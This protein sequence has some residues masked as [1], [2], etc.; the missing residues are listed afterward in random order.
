MRGFSLKNE[1]DR[2]SAASSVG[3]EP[4]QDRD[5]PPE[6]PDAD[7]DAESPPRTHGGRRSK[8]ELLAEHLSP[9]QRQVLAWLLQGESIKQVA[10]RL[11]LSQHTIGDY[12]KEIYRH[13]GVY[14]RSE[15]MAL[16][17]PTWY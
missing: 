15:L 16:F 7:S 4:R 1:E 3:G 17:V 5:P 12:V 10:A 9:R 2:E 6:T 14:S 8:A 13:F 11:G